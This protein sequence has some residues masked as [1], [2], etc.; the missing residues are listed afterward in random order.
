MFISD[1]LQIT[2]T[3]SVIR[4]AYNTYPYIPANGLIYQPISKQYTDEHGRQQ[5]W[6]SWKQAPIKCIGGGYIG[7]TPTRTG[8]FTVRNNVVAKPLY[9]APNLR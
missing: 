8:S 7:A 6:S 5:T 9:C 1:G 2:N 4:A 3:P